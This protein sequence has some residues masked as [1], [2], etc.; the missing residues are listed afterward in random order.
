LEADL[1]ISQREYF[2]QLRNRHDELLRGAYEFSE[3]S[4]LV[5]SEPGFVQLGLRHQ[6]VDSRGATD[7][8]NN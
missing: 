1:R 6:Q 5:R 2:L 4:C 8:N 3:T 7:E